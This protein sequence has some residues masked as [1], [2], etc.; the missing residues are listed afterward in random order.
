MKTSDLATPTAGTE[1]RTTCRFVDS[2]EF[3]RSKCPRSGARSSQ[4]LEKH[5]SINILHAALIGR[6]PSPYMPDHYRDHQAA[7]QRILQRHS[8]SGGQVLNL[9][10]HH[11]VQICTLASDRPRPPPQFPLGTRPPGGRR[12][13]SRDWQRC[14]KTEA[15]EVF[16]SGHGNCG[17]LG[18]GEG[19][20]RGRVPDSCIDAPPLASAEPL[21]VPSR[22]P[23]V[24]QQKLAAV[25]RTRA[26]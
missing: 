17:K 7:A 22:L 2:F 3:C 18:H 24:F 8:G 19:Q 26:T 20:G 9:I 15:E 16:A 10:L 14:Y 13:I 23:G 6:G 1:E 21:P 11:A 5:P 4:H 25:A 12:L